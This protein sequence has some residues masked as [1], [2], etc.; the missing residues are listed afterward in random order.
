MAIQ[1]T[2]AVIFNQLSS[3]VR[4]N[5]GQTNIRTQTGIGGKREIRKAKT[6]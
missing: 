2:R 5:G 1:V 3:F 4:Q 6:E